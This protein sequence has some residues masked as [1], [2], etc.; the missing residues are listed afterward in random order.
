MHL[1]HLRQQIDELEHRAEL[2]HDPIER[3]R[4]WQDCI[5]IE[6]SLEAL[7]EKL[8]QETALVD[9]ARKRLKRVRARG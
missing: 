4:L 6:R 7:A 1:D 8:V 5:A 9:Q 3:R 2:P